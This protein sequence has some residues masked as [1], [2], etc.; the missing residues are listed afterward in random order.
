MS[1]TISQYESFSFSCYSKNKVY[2]YYI[3]RIYRTIPQEVGNGELMLFCEKKLQEYIRTYTQ[4]RTSDVLYE[5]HT[6]KE[7]Q[8]KLSREFDE[9]FSQ[10]FTSYGCTYIR[11]R[12]IEVY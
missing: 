1:T 9:T 7:L 4:E 5:T 10:L 12:V 11:I 2:I 6:K 3:L 8:F